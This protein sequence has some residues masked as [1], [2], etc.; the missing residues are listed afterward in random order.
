M[1]VIIDDIRGIHKRVIVDNTRVYKW[2]SSPNESGMFRNEYTRQCKK[3]HVTTSEVKK[4]THKN[5]Q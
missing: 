4:N 1:K 5:T 2:G 3:L